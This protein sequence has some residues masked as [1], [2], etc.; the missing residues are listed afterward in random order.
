MKRNST[1]LYLALIVACICLFGIK[2]SLSSHS[3]GLGPEPSIQ[4]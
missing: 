3:T 4:A 2:Q 1:S